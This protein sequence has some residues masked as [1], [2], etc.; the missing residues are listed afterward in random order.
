MSQTWD[1]VN[2][3]T[4]HR[5]ISNAQEEEAGPTVRT[6]QHCFLIPLGNVKHSMQ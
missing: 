3:V 4:G 2:K 6:G 1:R 5:E